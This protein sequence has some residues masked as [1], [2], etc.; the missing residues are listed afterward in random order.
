M[1]I[2]ELEER[3]SAKHGRTAVDRTKL[4]ACC[5]E[6]LKIERRYHQIHVILFP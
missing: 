1:G 2:E 4:E 5:E 6:S 3:V